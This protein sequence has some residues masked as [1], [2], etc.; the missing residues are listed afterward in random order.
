MGKHAVAFLIGSKYDLFDQLDA[1]Y[2]ADISK[3][4]RKFAK[5]MKAPLIYCSACKAINV[6]KIFQIIVSKVFNVEPRVKELSGENEP[7][8]EYKKKQGEKK[9]KKKKKKKDEAGEGDA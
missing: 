9:K 3:H 8:I 2:K 7:I 4:A 6:N 1:A 5:A